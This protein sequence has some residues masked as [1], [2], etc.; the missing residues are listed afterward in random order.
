[1]ALVIAWCGW[2]STPL[3][4]IQ[5]KILKLSLGQQPAYAEEEPRTAS[6]R[7][8]AERQARTVN[9]PDLHLLVELAW[10]RRD[11]LD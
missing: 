8:S 3:V 10:F 7:V 4:S 9:P 1:L 5:Q 2:Q 6:R 11:H